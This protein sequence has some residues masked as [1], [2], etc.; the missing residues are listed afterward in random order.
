M[1]IKH[2][3]LHEV[4]RENDG[5]PVI[6]SLR[7]TE[8][9][10]EGLGVKLTEQLIQ[11]FDQSSL[12]IGEF[13]V[14]GDPNLE[15]AFEQQLKQFY[16]VESMSCHS[17][18]DMTKAMATRYS[19]II[20][21]PKL[22]S[23]KGGIL[24]FYEYDYNKS[25]QLAVAI[26][27]RIDGIDAKSGSLDLTPSTIIDL[28]RLHLGAAIDLTKWHAGLTHRHIK[29]KTG[30]SVD[31]REYFELFVGCQ[32]DKQAALRETTA[33]KNA[34]K[35]YSE[36]LNLDEDT[37]QDKLEVAHKFI[38]D[39]K[40]NGKEVLLSHI[41]NA[42]FPENSKAFLTVAKNDTHNISEQIAISPSELKRYVRLAGRGK[43]ISISFNNDLLNK[44]VK[45]E[46]KQLIFTDIP[47]SLKNSILELQGKNVE[48]HR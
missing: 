41:A 38:Q 30:Q 11:L 7:D 20:S 34:I 15:P 21:A 43:G 16:N 26:L 46:N 19:E 32:R 31:M 42:V 23:V 37:I 1:A 39:Q 13:G 45:Y 36:K 4:K 6:S 35:T 10:I 28:N 17:F 29:F 12:N 22:Q 9:S 47:E 25:I 40:K 8:N 44:T 14:D 3:I 27:D 24:V 18:V 48:G 5:S 2:V 33:L